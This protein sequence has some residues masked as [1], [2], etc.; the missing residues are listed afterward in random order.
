MN[1]RVLVRDKVQLVTANVL[2]PLGAIVK[3]TRFTR[4]HKTGIDDKPF[5][6][7]HAIQ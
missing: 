6:G 5:K 7:K 3:R 2:S 1:F 4:E